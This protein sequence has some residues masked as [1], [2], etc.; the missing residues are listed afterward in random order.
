MAREGDTPID[1]IERAARSLERAMGGLGP[2]GRDATAARLCQRLGRQ[3][4]QA[5]YRHGLRQG[6]CRKRGCDSRYGIVRVVIDT[7][8]PE[9]TD[10][11]AHLECA[12]CGHVWGATAIP[13]LRLR[14]GALP[15]VLL[16]LILP[17]ARGTGARIW[18]NRNGR[19]IRV[20]TDALTVTD[21][22]YTQLADALSDHRA[23]RLRWLERRE[24]AQARR[25]A[26]AA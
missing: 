17:P 15:R 23:R 22:S 9:R 11:G 19:A 6:R 10:R 1:D 21:A 16:T 18:Y 7:R 20:G 14:D 25:E 12:L 13:D 26:A 24:A 5:D 2:P 4:L 3:R 8:D